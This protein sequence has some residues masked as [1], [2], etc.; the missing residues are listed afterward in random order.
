MYMYVCSKVS[1]V[2]LSSAINW[3]HALTKYAL[4]NVSAQTLVSHCG[5]TIAF[6]EVVTGSRLSQWTCIREA[7][8]YILAYHILSAT[9][10]HTCASSLAQTSCPFVRTRH[11]VDTIGLPHIYVYCQY[12]TGKCPPLYLKYLQ[13]LHEHTYLWIGTHLYTVYIHIYCIIYCTHSFIT[14]SFTA[15]H[16]HCMC[17]HVSHELLQRIFNN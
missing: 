8:T 6:S 17:S 14:K 16:H 4:F 12:Y 1:I 7:I 9:L 15:D 10:K 11:C 13:H 5:R 2:R 3:R